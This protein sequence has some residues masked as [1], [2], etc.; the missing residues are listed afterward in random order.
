MWTSVEISVLNAGVLG[1]NAVHAVVATGRPCAAQSGDDVSV[2]RLAYV[3]LATAD[4]NT[5]LMLYRD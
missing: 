4:H 5:A 2:N 1:R 3:E